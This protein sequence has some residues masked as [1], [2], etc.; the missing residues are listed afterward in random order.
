[1]KKL[2]VLLGMLLSVTVGG[3]GM[4]QASHGGQELIAYGKGTTVSARS[5]DF[6]ARL[7]DQQAG[8]LFGEPHGRMHLEADDGLFTID[9]DVTCL[10]IVGNQAVVGGRVTQSEGIASRGIIFFVTDNTLST[11]DQIVPDGWF[12]TLVPESPQVC[13]PPSTFSIPL[14]SGDIVVEQN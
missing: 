5:F 8:E 7:S 14:M 13:P 2:L 4:A 6:N 10:T 3:A 12:A 1:M 11:G 9:A